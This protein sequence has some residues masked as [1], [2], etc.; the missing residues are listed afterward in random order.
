MR[1]LVASLLLSAAAIPAFA[2]AYPYPLE[3]PAPEDRVV[4]DL[5]PAEPAP[6]ASTNE[7]LS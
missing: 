2:D 6:A 4:Y 5:G 1:N 7:E 3:D